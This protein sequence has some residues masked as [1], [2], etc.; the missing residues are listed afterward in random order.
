[1]PKLKSLKIIHNRIGKSPQIWL[2][3]VEEKIHF[4]TQAM[5]IEA[6][7]LSADIMKD[8]IKNSGYKL[9][10]L[11]N[12]I[13]SEPMPGTG[14]GTNSVGIKIGKIADFPKDEEG[15][16]YWNAFN[17]GWLPPKNLGYFTGGSGLS[18]DKVPPIA[19]M[20]G[21]KWVHT[22]DKSD[23]FMIPNKPIKPLQ[24]AEIGYE[25]LVAHISKEIDELLRSI[26]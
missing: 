22:G 14:F 24:F 25:Y 4:E 23:Y 1:M 11:A 10:K 18:G 19:G 17:D 13:K 15:R 3:E 8:I 20:S 21:Q 26:K 2:K 16:D 7:D 6:G 5:L 9:E 12:A